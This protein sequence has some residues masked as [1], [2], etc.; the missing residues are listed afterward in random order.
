MQWMRTIL[1]LIY[2]L[3]VDDGSFAVAILVWLGIIWMLA[4]R[5]GVP[6]GVV[7]PLLFVGLAT[8]L[9]TSTAWQAR[10]RLPE[11]SAAAK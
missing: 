2:G 6:R 4:S 5:L 1:S 10:R 9:V 3:F 7:G 11:K 8:I